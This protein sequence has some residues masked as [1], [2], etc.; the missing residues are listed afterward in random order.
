MSSAAKTLELL[1]YFTTARPEI[2]LS[3]LCRLAGRDKATAYRHLQAL[4]EAGFV[5]QNPMTKHYR[6]GP[7]L[8][9]LAQTR[10]ATVPRKAAAETALTKLADATG[11]TSHVSVLSGTTLYALVACEAHSHSTRV[12]IDVDTLAL[13]ATASGLCALAFG[14]S[15]LMDSLRDPLPAFTP[16][17]MTTVAQVTQAVDA[18]RD[19]GFAQA[20]RYYG[21]D[22][23]S[24]AAPI[25]DHTGHLAG[26]VAVACV[27]TRFTPELGA[28]VM[29]HLTITAQ[30]ITRNWG[31]T[32]PHSVPA[33]WSRTL[34]NTLDIA[35]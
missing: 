33:A 1:S 3:A 7:A 32:L 16:S 29:L 27:A 12:I 10:E 35:S 13:H 5:E 8:L 6:L 14:S 4:E 28:N 11:E 18:I 24:I 21:E 25:F 9:Q 30:D 22:T 31:G 15:D 23:R 19:T 26:T 20:D 2:G 17:T 34:S